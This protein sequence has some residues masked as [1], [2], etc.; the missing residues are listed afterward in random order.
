[1]VIFKFY[2]SLHSSI[3][4]SHFSFSPYYYHEFIGCYLCILQSITVIHF[5]A[6]I[7]PNLAG[8]F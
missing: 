8:V 4:K 1:M 5:D 3:K 7:V 2:H 6:Q